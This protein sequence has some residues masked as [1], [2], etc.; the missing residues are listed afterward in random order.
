[1]PVRLQRKRT[2]GWRKPENAV[3]VDRTTRW[4]NPFKVGKDGTAEECVYKYE[5]MLFPYRHGGTLEDFYISDANLEDIRRNLAGKDLLCFCPL[6]QP[7]HA[8]VLLKAAN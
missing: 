5:E 7:C 2:K 1:M 4:G 6:G 3:C 8:D